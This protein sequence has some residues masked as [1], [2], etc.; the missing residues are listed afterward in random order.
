MR[1]VTHAR[2]MSPEALAERARWADFRQKVETEIAGAERVAEQAVSRHDIDG[3]VAA[4]ERKAAL[5]AML[6]LIDRAEL[7][8]DK[9]FFVRTPLTSPYVGLV[10]GWDGTGQRPA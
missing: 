9:A 8:A 4:L 5:T 2:P 3:A 10:S 7:A 6:P 1:T